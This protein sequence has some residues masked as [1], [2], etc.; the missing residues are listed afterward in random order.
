MV[1]IIDGWVSNL[2]LNLGFDTTN[3][4]V[5]FVLGF[6]WFNYIFTITSEVLNVSH[7]KTAIPKEMMDVVNAADYM[8]SQQYTKAKTQFKIVKDTWSFIDYHVMWYIGMYNAIDVYCRS[9]MPESSWMVGGNEE[10]WNGCKFMV[11]LV[12]I[13]MV[14]DQPFSLYHTFVLEE[15]FGFNKTTMATYIKDMVKGQMLTIVI[16][17]PVFSV[18]IYTL[19]VMGDNAWLYCW[20][21][22]T[23]VSLLLQFLAPVLILPLFNELTPLEDGEIKS[24]LERYANEQSFTFSGVF[25]MDGSTRSTHSNA[26]FTGFGR[27]KRICLY[28]TLVDKSSTEEILAILGHEIGHYK[29]R[30][31]WYT[32]GFNI[33]QQG[34]ILYMMQQILEQ[35][36]VF[37]AFKIATPSI[38]MGL[39]LFSG[40][41]AP[42]SFVIGIA[43]NIYSRKN[44]FEADE[45]SVDTVKKPEALVT[46]LKKLSKNSNSNLT[47]HP[48]YVFV[49]YSHPP[50]VERI[51][52]LRSYAKKVL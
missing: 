23:S 32:T 49:N 14:L 11:A 3:P 35:E 33:L 20:V 37:Q 26:F 9:V 41:F 24:Q 45:F 18:I 27:F 2:D 34:A 52:H 17:A 36:I 16:G 50:I 19:Q 43:M 1:E 46:G 6:V 31:I 28:D 47:P 40:L 51:K 30:H 42:I 39:M 22:M 7:W 21:I 38:Y 12:L 15:R 25:V 13:S 8:K 5:L 29:R 48:F 44:E 10:V 4:I